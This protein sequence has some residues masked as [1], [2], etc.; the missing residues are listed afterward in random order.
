MSLMM[1]G[2]LP[3]TAK[4]QQFAPATTELLT[5]ISRGLVLVRVPV[6]AV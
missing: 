1:F 3:A 2:N 6:K 4:G 5:L